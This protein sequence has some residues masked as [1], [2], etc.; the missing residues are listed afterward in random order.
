M[1]SMRLSYA[2]L[3]GMGHSLEP[4]IRKI[5]DERSKAIE[6]VC[7]HPFFKGD[8]YSEHT[9]LLKNLKEEQFRLSGKINLIDGFSKIRP[10]VLFVR[11][12]SC[13]FLFSLS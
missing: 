7:E 12:F 2:L 10:S 11:N 5:C 13:V 6:I 9:S 4:G 3:P 1:R 8:N